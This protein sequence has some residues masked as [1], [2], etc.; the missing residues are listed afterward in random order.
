MKI[1][2]FTPLVIF[3][4]SIIIIG[5]SSNTLW[6]QPQNDTCNSPIGIGLNN[7][8]FCPTAGVAG[9][10]VGAT[11]DAG[12]TFSCDAPGNNNSV[13]Y[14]FSAPA[15]GEVNIQITSIT[16]DHKAA[17]LV[18]GCGGAEAWCNLSPDNEN[19]TGLF[20]NTTYYI[21]V[22]SD[23]GSEGAFQV[24]VQRI[25]VQNDDCNAAIGIGVNNAGFCPAGG[26][27]GTTVNSSQDAGI[28][29]SCDGTG[30]NN[31]VWYWFI[32]PSSG[33][34]NVQIASTAG[35]H[36]AAIFQVGCG[37]AEVWCHLTPDNEDVTGLTA[38]GVYYISVWSD[39]G[40]EGAFEI[41]IQEILS[42][43]VALESF[44]GKGEPHGNLLSWVTSSEQ[45][46]EE[47]NIE[48]SENG[49]DHWERIGSLSATGFSTEKQTYQFIDRG[50]KGS[51]YY[52]K[53]QIVDFDGQEEISNMIYVKRA[54]NPTLAI[55][56]Y[57]NP[58]S[59]FITIE[60]N[61][62]IEQSA[63][64][65]L[66]NTTGQLMLE[67]KVILKKGINQHTVK[68]ASLSGGLYWLIFNDGANQVTQKVIKQ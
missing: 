38:S 49:R 31:S 51:D 36:K 57:P 64:I 6:A 56:V 5:I 55:Q 52:Y 28:T 35:D 48:R 9:T 15:N 50:I 44:S 62:A 30:F 16:G 54:V 32:A 21:A 7:A 68:T 46:T 61:S 4:M 42:L 45:N 34:V 2:F 60:M 17:L 25:P 3:L 67:E 59:H 33:E 14:W 27:A 47:F 37:G 66:T 20:G 29:F 41:C 39:A 10:T 23:A 11:E 22:W 1:K 43:P 19:I 40:S 53:L 13:W 18:L 24:C 26:V 65:K 58:M 63:T 12:I 8:G